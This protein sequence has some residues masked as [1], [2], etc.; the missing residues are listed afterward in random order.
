MKRVVCILAAAILVSSAAAAKGFHAGLKGGLSTSTTTGVPLGL[1]DTSFRGGFAGGLSLGYSFNDYF[2]LQPEILYV[3]KGLGGS[4]SN[5]FSSGDFTG[6]Y[7]YVEIPVL[8]KLTMSSRSRVSPYV[9]FGPSLGLNVKADVEID[10]APSRLNEAWTESWDYSSVTNT[11]EFSVAFGGG[12]EFDAWMGAVTLDGRFDLG[13]SKV[14]KGGTISTI[15]DDT[16]FIEH[17]SESTSKNMGF[18]LL[19]GYAF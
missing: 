17:V 16:E 5:R 6:E 3:M 2:T 8:A 11:L 9:F 12:L 7:D 19:V 14:T 13:L 4:V 15:I 1:D 18:L 10:W